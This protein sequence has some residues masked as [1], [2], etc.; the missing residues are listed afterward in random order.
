LLAVN[1]FGVSVVKNEDVA[2][3]RIALTRVA[4]RIDR[5]V[6]GGGLTR[7]QL[8]ILA[9]VSRLGPIGLTELAEFEDVNPTMLSRIVARLT[10]AELVRR[11]ADPADGRASRI[12]LTPRGRRLHQNLR[13]Q[14]T[15]LL[16]ERLDDLPEEVTLALLAA[17]PVLETL[18][19]RMGGPTASGKSTTSSARRE[20]VGQP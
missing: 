12:E 4:R 18:A 8:S 3:L 19:D 13:D 5:Q 15:K 6:S 9:A 20:R 17:I 11:L 16:A 10:E 1:Q 14:R 7:T 2:R